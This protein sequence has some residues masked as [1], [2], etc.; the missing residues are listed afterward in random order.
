MKK[1]EERHGAKEEHGKTAQ[2]A[3]T[4]HEEVNED[5]SRDQG[6]QSDQIVLKERGPSRRNRV[7]AHRSRTG[8]R[9]RRRVPERVVALG[10]DELYCIMQQ[11][12][13]LTSYRTNLN[14]LYGQLLALCRTKCDA[15]VA[16]ALM[17]N[18]Y[19]AQGNGMHRAWTQVSYHALWCWDVATHHI[20]VHNGSV[21]VSV[22]F[23]NGSSSVLRGFYVMCDTHSVNV[24]SEN[25]GWIGFDASLRA[26]LQFVSPE[27]LFVSERF[28]DAI[29]CPVFVRPRR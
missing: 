5:A 1:V 8:R 29:V 6:D 18:A 2:S 10:S 9:S 16:R 22:Y 17:R 21:R 3:G 14:R 4:E 11:L 15:M 13:Y 12:L 19:F 24:L 7:A 28:R 20:F 26:A 25:F 23:H 27:K